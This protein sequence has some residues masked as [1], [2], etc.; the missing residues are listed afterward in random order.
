MKAY[1]LYHLFYS[2]WRIFRIKASSTLPNSSGPVH[3]HTHT[4]THT[5]K[6][7]SVEIH[8]HVG[9]VLKMKK[10]IKFRAYNLILKLEN[11]FPAENA[12][13]L[14]CAHSVCTVRVSALQHH[15]ICRKCIFKF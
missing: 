4:H 11:G 3:T 12:V 7:I 15:I 10:A 5:H 2:Q 9:N 13:Q 8:N 14:K 6:H 1:S